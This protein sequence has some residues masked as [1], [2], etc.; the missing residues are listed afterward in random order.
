MFVS[1]LV[2][3]SAAAQ[4]LGKR[5]VVDRLVDVFFWHA[6][7]LD[8]QSQCLFA[9]FRIVCHADTRAALLAH[10]EVVDAVLRHS[11]SKNAVLNGIAH[12]V[13]D[14][15]VTFDRQSADR[16]KLPRF[17]AFNQEWLAAIAASEA[18]AAE[19]AATE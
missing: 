11:T 15:I 3:Y 5:G 7:D 2:L 16:L 14:A 1:A 10:Q 18:A 19:A 6:A 13:I 12:A 17:D 9:F 8:V 4:A